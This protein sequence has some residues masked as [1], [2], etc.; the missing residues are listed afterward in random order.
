MRA[1]CFTHM[2]HQNLSDILAE[3]FS[4]ISNGWMRLTTDVYD[5][6]QSALS[7]FLGGGPPTACRLNH[8][9]TYTTC[10]RIKHIYFTG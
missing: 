2:M 6:I 10:D 9:V 1:N 7:D 8:D 4:L 5:L 3:R